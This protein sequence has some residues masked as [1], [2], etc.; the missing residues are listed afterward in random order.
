MSTSF[1]ALAILAVAAKAL[2]PLL[3]VYWTS[4]AVRAVHVWRQRRLLDRC[5]SIFIL[6]VQALGNGAPESAANALRDIRTLERRWRFGQGW[7]VRGLVILIALAI[8]AVVFVALQAAMLYLVVVAMDPSRAAEFL[9]NIR[10]NVLAEDNPLVRFWLGIGLAYALTT[11]LQWPRHTEIDDCGDRLER[12]I[13]SPRGVTATKANE[14]RGPYMRGLDGLTAYEILG[15]G[16]RF[17]MLELRAARRRLA[18]QYH[19]DRW[20]G[21]SAAM[22]KAAEDAMKRIN[23]AFDELR[24]TA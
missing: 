10:D 1:P 11:L 2:V 9:R 3:G 23:G 24:A 19:P 22:R 13:T 17:T 5:R 16:R 12:F 21:A 4:Q 14:P 18:A 8:G 6:G 7:I 15:V 20:H